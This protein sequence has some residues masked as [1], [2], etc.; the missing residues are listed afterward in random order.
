MKPQLRPA[1]AA[2]LA[3]IGLDMHWLDVRPI[4]AET[5]A[6]DAQTPQPAPAA[7]A[8]QMAKPAH[9]ASTERLPAQAPVTRAPMPRPSSRASDPA[10]PIAA[11]EAIPSLADADLPTLARIVGACRQC[12]RHEQRLR[13]VPGAG[14]ADRPYYLIVAEQPGI[15]DEVAG[16]PFQGDSGRLL[17]A[18]LAAVR[19][20]HAEARYGTYVMKCRAPGGHEPSQAEI[21]ACVPHL[22]R[23]IAL[24]QPRWILALGRVATQA[25]LGDAADL[26]ALRGAPHRYRQED[27][28]EIPVWVTHQPASLLVRSALKAEAWRDLV[29]LAQ[30]VRAAEPDSAAAEP[31]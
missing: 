19:L 25:V 3:E 10:A 12:P 31:A 6:L 24:L 23:E 17:T 22:H 16:Q 30:A 18:M 26:D 5:L 11:S 15:D 27:G 4:T 1:Q 8:G 13:A 28:R 29:G 14:Q 20:P 21:A 7:V 2:W 9:D